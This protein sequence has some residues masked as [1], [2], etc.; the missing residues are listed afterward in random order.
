M[1]FTSPRPIAASEVQHAN[2]E[3]MATFMGLFGMT[4]GILFHMN[5]F[6]LSIKSPTWFP[7]PASRLLAT[8]AIGGGFV[9]GRL[10]GSFLF[11]NPELQRLRDSHE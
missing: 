10:A 8:V 1:S 5:F 9:A 2:G 7:S 4:Q 6:K 3:P 11:S